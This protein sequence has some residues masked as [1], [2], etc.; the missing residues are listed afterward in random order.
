MKRQKNNKNIEKLII[1][2]VKYKNKLNKKF[3]K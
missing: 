2:G 1:C 3:C